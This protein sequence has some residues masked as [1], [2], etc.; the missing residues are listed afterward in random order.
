MLESSMLDLLNNIVEVVL[1]VHF[2]YITD[3]YLKEDLMQEGY[4]KAYQLLNTG[5]YD[6]N[7][8]LR[9]YLYTG[10]RNAMTNYLYHSKKELHSSLDLFEDNFQVSYVPSE[11]DLSLPKELIDKYCLKY[12]RYGDRRFSVCKKLSD[13][14]FITPKYREVEVKNDLITKAIVIELVWSLIR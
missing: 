4:L 3:P 5:N 10:V 1:H 11:V 14:G 9:N 8:N 12:K 13:M 6:P 2:Y 7:Q